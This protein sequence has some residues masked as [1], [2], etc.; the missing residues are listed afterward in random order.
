MLSL[1]ECK[2]VKGDLYVSFNIF[3][4]ETYKRDLWAQMKQKCDQWDTFFSIFPHP[5][6]CV[7]TKYLKLTLC[8]PTESCRA[9]STAPRC[10]SGI[11]YKNQDVTAGC[12]SAWPGIFG[13]YTEEWVGKNRKKCVP[14]VT[15]LCVAMQS[16][17]VSS[18]FH[19]HG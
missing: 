11:E 17:N 15:L 1:L 13:G 5:F 16:H 3:Q 2:Y 12:A 8:T 18:I 4:K 14:L 6:F 10:W 9:W 19:C 7:T